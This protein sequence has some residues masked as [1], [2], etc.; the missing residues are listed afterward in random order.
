MLQ[1]KSLAKVLIILI[2]LILVSGCA[3]STDN[4]QPS[5]CIIFTDS[6]GRTVSVPKGTIDA[7]VL[8]GSLADIWHLA[9]GNLLATAKDAWE[10][11]GIDTDAVNLG[12][13]KEP[14]VELL[15]SVCPDFVIASSNT[16]SNQDLLPLLEGAGI[17]VA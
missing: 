13:V 6:L 3:K 7:A 10:D 1:K 8:V 15:L 11:F 4:S 2:C 12:T 9:G 5:D 14:N 17:T 16:A